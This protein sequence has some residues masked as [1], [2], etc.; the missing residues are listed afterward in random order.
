MRLMIGIYLALG[1]ICLLCVAGF[2][3]VGIQLLLKEQ[4]DTHYRHNI[5]VEE[6]VGI[7]LILLGVSSLPLLA[8]Y[9][10]WRRWYMMRLIL[11][12]LCWWSIGWSVFIGMVALAHWAKLID[13]SGLLANEPPGETLAIAA[14][15][16]AF[17]SWQY[18]VLSRPAVRR[19]FLKSA[20]PA[21]IFDIGEE[22]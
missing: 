19:S 17:H 11:I 7:T 13:G 20:A 8:A 3:V 21:E 5:H 14:A 22:I 1:V 9:G 2:E 16:I 4:N 12:G 18:W 10:L 15:V 6:L